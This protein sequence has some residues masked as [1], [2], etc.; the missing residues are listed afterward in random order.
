MGAILASHT[1]VLLARHAVRCNFGKAWQIVTQAGRSMYPHYGVLVFLF[2]RV[3]WFWL[4]DLRL[5]Q[6]N[7]SPRANAFQ[8]GEANFGQVIGALTWDTV[9]VVNDPREIVLVFV[10]GRI[11][12]R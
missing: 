2:L 1:D 3:H 11:F 10:T 8:A 5:T 12:S 6:V 9:T 7:N 4:G